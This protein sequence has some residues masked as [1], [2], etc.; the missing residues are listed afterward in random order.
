MGSQ[1][2]G[3]RKFLCMAVYV[4]AGVSVACGDS[5]TAPT[6]Q[7]PSIAGQ[8]SGSYRVTTCN[9]NATATGFCA[10]LGQGGN[11]VFTP[12]QSGAAVTGTL[13]V[14][15]L[16]IPVSGNVTAA[17][18]LSLAGSGPVLT[19][20]TLTLTSWQYQI[21]GSQMT[22]PFGFTVAGGV[23]LGSATV[24]ATGTLTR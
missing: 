7:I 20:I 3:M 5:P 24:S 22:G 21:T 11:L 9:E 13:V 10:A 4:F 15:T 1:M 12:T 6:P 2:S 17:N 16:S 8:W 19:G 23:P 14:G 18:L